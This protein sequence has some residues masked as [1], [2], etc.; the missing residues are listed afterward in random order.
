MQV[1][2]TQCWGLM[3]KYLPHSAKRNGS[4][5]GLRG[6]FTV[7]GIRS[8]S[9]WISFRRLLE[10]DSRSFGLTTTSSAATPSAPVVTKLSNALSP[11]S[12]PSSRKLQHRVLHSL[13]CLQ[14]NLRA[15][16]CPGRPKCPRARRCHLCQGISRFRVLFRA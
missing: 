13:Q 6:Q 9:S 14:V 5:V 15:P 11:S 4:S 8:A 12:S 7:T 1:A 2:R 3:A 16:R 10:D